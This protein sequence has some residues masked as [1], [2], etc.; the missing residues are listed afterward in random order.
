METL[1]VVFMVGISLAYLVR[2]FKKEI[3][4]QGACASCKGNK[5]SCGTSIKPMS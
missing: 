3:S 4:G 5:G 2:N 1:A